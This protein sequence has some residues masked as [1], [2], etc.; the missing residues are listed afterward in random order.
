M[1]EIDCDRWV[2]PFYLSILHGNYAT[3]ILNDAEREQFHADVRLA[4]A[5]IT[6]EIAQQLI[7]GGWR[8]AIVGSWF[9]GLK[10]LPSC[11]KTIEAC[12][13]EHKYDLSQQS[14]AFALACYGDEASA[15]ALVRHLSRTPREFDSYNDLGWAI[16]ALMWI[17][18][19]RGNHHAEPFITPGG[20]WHSF[21][22]SSDSSSTLEYCKDYFWDKMHYCRTH[23]FE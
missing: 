4:L 3:T 13:L 14:H 9:A 6:P 21:F 18:T 7:L 20:L 12:L 15:D 17:D 22:F 5:E 16:P 8:E 11:W 1:N 10:K 19:E 23:F 2:A